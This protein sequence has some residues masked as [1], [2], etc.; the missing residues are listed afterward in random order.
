M[1]NKLGGGH[2]ICDRCGEIIFGSTIHHCKKENVMSNKIQI[3]E[4]HAREIWESG[5]E[6]FIKFMKDEGYIRKSELQRKVEEVE[7]MY[8]SLVENTWRH[9]GFTQNDLMKKYQELIQ[10]LKKDHPEFKE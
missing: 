9:C 8:E 5:F 6:R 4:E 10:L 3:T 2:R 7:E 1:N